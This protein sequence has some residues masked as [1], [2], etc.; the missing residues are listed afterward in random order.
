MS[1]LFFKV[2]KLQ[3]QCYRI[4]G[5]NEYPFPL[6]ISDGFMHSKRGFIKNPLSLVRDILFK[7][8]RTLHKSSNSYEITPFISSIKITNKHISQ[9]KCIGRVTEWINK[10]EC[11]Q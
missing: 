11:F 8:I 3:N 2:I 6:D 10:N 5:Y 9:Q 1:I 7:S 4:L